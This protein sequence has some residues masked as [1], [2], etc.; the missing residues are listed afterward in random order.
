MP[1]RPAG[2]GEARPV[3]PLPRGRRGLAPAEGLLAGGPSGP[4]PHG[5]AIGRAWP[6]GP[7][8]PVGGFAFSSARGAVWADGR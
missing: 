6:H 8:L 3:A 5:T 4:W 7:S 1:G 2:G